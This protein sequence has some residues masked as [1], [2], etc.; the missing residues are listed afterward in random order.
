MDAHVL[1]ELADTL[2]QR[3]D[4]FGLREVYELE[5]RVSHTV[6]QME[7]NGFG[8]DLVRLDAFIAESTEQ[9]ERLKAEL[10]EE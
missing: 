3:I 6:D 10:E 7:R 9:A 2:L 5:R 8:I 1:P 4:K